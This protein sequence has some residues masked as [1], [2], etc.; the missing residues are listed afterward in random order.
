MKQLEPGREPTRDGRDPDGS[1]DLLLRAAEVGLHTVHLKR[2]KRPPVFTS[3][4]ETPAPQLLCPACDS[5][6]RYRQTVISGVQPIERW[7]YFEC[8]TCGPF[9]YRDRTRKL[10]PST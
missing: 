5:P 6:L 1:P 7:D 2:T 8:R 4:P 10:R 9:V 3:T